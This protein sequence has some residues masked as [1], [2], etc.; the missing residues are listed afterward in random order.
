[1]TFEPPPEPKWYDIQRKI[2]DRKTVEKALEEVE[3]EGKAKEKV[4][5]KDEVEVKVEKKKSRKP[6]SNLVRA[7]R[8]LDRKDEKTC[9]EC[10]RRVPLA[11]IQQ[12]LAE[13]CDAC[14]E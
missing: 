6:T 7:L 11:E 5:V 8:L 4:E 1:M 12:G 10:G 2:V 9:A 3:E 13:A 14:R